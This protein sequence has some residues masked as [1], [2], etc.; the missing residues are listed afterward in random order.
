MPTFSLKYDDKMLTP[1]A[2]LSAWA[3]ISMI[4]LTVALVFYHIVRKGSIKANPRFAVMITIGLLVVSILYMVVPLHNFIPRMHRVSEACKSD[5]RCGEQQ[6]AD[7]R[8]STQTNVFLGTALIL[9]ELAIAYL[10]INTV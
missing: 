8:L 3:N 7:L 4:T 10:V 9:V 6:Q 2:V 1:E 5:K